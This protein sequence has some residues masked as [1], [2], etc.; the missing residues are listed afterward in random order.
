MTPSHSSE[1]KESPLKWSRNRK[2]IAALTSIIA[3]SI[4]T[5]LPAV[6]N[7]FISDDFDLFT[8]IEAAERSPRW[9]FETTPEFFRLT[10][11]IYFGACYWLFGLNPEPYYWA[12]IALHA[13]VSVLVYV[14][15][16]EVSGSALSAWTAGLFFA[17]YE[18]HQEAVMWI[19][20]ANE[21]ILALSCLLFLSFWRRAAEHT[22]KRYL[23]LAHMMFVVAL[24]SKE[25]SVI[26]VPLAALQ[27][28]LAGYSFRAILRKSIALIVM[29]GLFLL[30]WYT[31]AQRNPFVTRGYY[32]FGFQFMSVYARSVVRLAAQLAPLGAALFIARHRLNRRNVFDG[33][34]SRLK[35]GVVSWRNAAIFFGAILLLAIVPYSFLTYLNHIPSRHTYLPSIGLAGLFGMAFASIYGGMT[36]DRSRRICTLLVCA[37]LTGNISYIWLKKA[38]QYRERAAPTRELIEILNASDKP[39]LP[40]HVC[41]FPLDP[42]VFSETVKRFT[43][44][45]S[46][47]VI[48]TDA[49]DDVPGAVMLWDESSSQYR[50][51]F[52][53]SHA[54]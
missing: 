30:L 53:E 21:T 7:F 25:A 23:V 52:S 24:F 26:L 9:F 6:G 20:A 33:L 19:S 17:A 36:T 51:N 12:G 13:M 8:V 10:S 39:Q 47:Q 2:Q 45:D 31:V 3:V 54:D 27:L 35:S 11:F 22:S 4:V 16:K 41:R 32:A 40:L 49:C 14:L 42:W 48:L 38:P 34:E 29:A 18:R 44:F 46:S 15:V 43:R 5:Y 50:V 1:P 37:L 28:A